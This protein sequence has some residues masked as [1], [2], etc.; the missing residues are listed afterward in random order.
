MKLQERNKEETCM[1]LQEKNKEETRMKLR[2]RNKE[3]RNKKQR[4]YREVQMSSAI[5]FI[6]TQSARL[7][8]F[9]SGL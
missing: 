4:D 7:T 2:E 8:C 3:Q 5:L 6:A 9:L 1:K